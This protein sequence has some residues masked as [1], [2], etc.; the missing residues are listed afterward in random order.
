MIKRY[1]YLLL[2]ST[3]SGCVSLNTEPPAAWKPQASKLGETCSGLT[4]TYKDDGSQMGFGCSSANCKARLSEVLDGESG[5]SSHKLRPAPPYK[6]EAVQ[7][8]FANENIEF[9]FLVDG[10]IIDTYVFDSK[11]KSYVCNIDGAN[12]D[13]FAGVPSQG[14]GAWTLAI[15]KKSLVLNRAQDGALV[16]RRYVPRLDLLFAVIPIP[17]AEGTWFRFPIAP[18]SVLD[19]ERDANP[20]FRPLH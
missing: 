18:S 13:Q 3:V 15:E 17:S 9:K 1:F 19:V 5:N 12:V 8:D 20:A 11:A 10:K 14:P 6:I 7:I 16:V 4:G 2:L